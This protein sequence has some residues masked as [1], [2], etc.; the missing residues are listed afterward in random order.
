VSEPVGARSTKPSGARSTKPSGARSTTYLDAATAAPLHPAASAA[1]HAALADGWADPDRLY[2]EGRRARRLLDGAR[3]AVAAVVGVRADE[4][5]FCPSGTTAAHLAV[6]GTLAG[7]RRVGASYV[8]SAV[9]HSCVLAAA[10]RHADE[11]GQVITIGVNRTGTVDADEYAAALRADTA[12]A[13]LQ[14]ANHEVGT[15]QPVDTVG[16]ACRERGVPLHV[17]AAQSLGRT[18]LPDS[19]DLLS[20]SARKWGGPTGVGVLVVR[21]GVRW[22]SPWPE[23]EHESGRM[24]GPVP[25][26]LVLAAA[27][28]LEAR[29]REQE[30]EATRLSALVDVIR[31]ELPRRI[32]DVEVL[33][34]PVR[35]L[36]HLVAFSCLYVAGEA[37]QTALDRAGFSVSSGSSCSSSA[38]TPSHVLEAMGVLTHGNVRVSLHGGVTQEDVERFL[39]VLP[40]MVDELRRTVGAQGL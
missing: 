36:P 24:P 7:R 1:L 9:E 32:P 19:W 8:V 22:R 39:D 15:L 10:R 17:D 37:L 20:A 35:R 4:V 25:L 27:A 28:S 13:S 34:E 23:D 26:P 21:R 33:G 5:T 31:A 11:G 6:L 14:S 38:L 18:A 40:P 16:P 3:A 29:A 2:R 30:Q 12:L